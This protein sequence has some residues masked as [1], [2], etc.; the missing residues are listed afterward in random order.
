[1]SYRHQEG[2]CNLD[3]ESQWGGLGLQIYICKSSAHSV[4]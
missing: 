1:M 4:I 3:L 2:N